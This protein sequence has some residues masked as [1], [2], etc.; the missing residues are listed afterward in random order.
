MS[1]SLVLGLAADLLA[2][3]ETRQPRHHHVEQQQVGLEFLDDLQSFLAVGGGTDFAFEIAQVGLEQLDVLQVV[4]GDQDFGRS[5]GLIQFVFP[6]SPEEAC[7]VQAIAESR[8]AAES[9]APDA[10]S[11]SRLVLRSRRA[12]NCAT[13]WSNVA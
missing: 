6:K 10:D 9:H 2:D 5:R 12:S 7:R 8:C 11:R 13:P 1:R 3:L 4:V